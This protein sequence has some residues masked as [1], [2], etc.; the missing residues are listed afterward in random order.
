MKKWR[1]SAT[2]LAATA[3]A[4]APFTV[5]AAPPH[6]RRD[7]AAA[8]DANGTNPGPSPPPPVAN[9]DNRFAPTPCTEPEAN[10]VAKSDVDVEPDADPDSAADAAKAAIPELPLDDDAGAGGVTGPKFAAGSVTEISRRG[11][12]PALGAETPERFADAGLPDEEET[13]PG[14]TPGPRGRDD[15][16]VRAVVDARTPDPSV[17]SNPTEPADPVV[18]A[19]ATGIDDTAEPMPSATASAPNRPT[20][21]TA[22]PAAADSAA[23]GARRPYSMD[24]TRPVAE[25][26]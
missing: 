7:D 15:A 9:Q 12:T 21:Q 11:A 26:R 10:T 6:S 2:G 1:K 22:P 13:P 24:R 5:L 16:L 8:G 14:E 3:A 20:Y 4:T 17:E 19:N 25:R 18:S 23:V